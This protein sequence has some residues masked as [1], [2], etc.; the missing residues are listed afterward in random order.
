MDITKPLLVLAVFLAVVKSQQKPQISMYPKF[1]QLYSGDTITLCCECD[2]T[3]TVKWFLNE[4]TTTQTNTTWRIAAVSAKNSSGSYT[5]EINGVKSNIFKIEV[6]DFLPPASLL[7]KS[8]MPVVTTYGS[9]VLEL[10]MEDGLQGWNCS[11]FQKKESNIKIRRKLLNNNHTTVTFHSLRQKEDIA[12][13]WC[14]NENHRS[15][16]ITIRRSDQMTVLETPPRPAVL[17]EKLTLHCVVRMAPII[18]SAIFYKDGKELPNDGREHQWNLKTVTSEEQE[19]IVTAPPPK[20]VLSGDMSCSCSSCPGNTYHWYYRQ[21]NQPWKLKGKGES[22]VW[23]L[24]TG[25]E[26]A[27]TAVWKNGRSA[28]SNTLRHAAYPT[29]LI[30]SGLVIVFGTILVIVAIVLFKRRRT[31]REAIYQDVPL[32]TVKS[33]DGDRDYEQLRKKG[34]SVRDGEYDTLTTPAEDKQKRDGEY[35]ALTKG[36]GNEGVY[37]T[38]GMVGEKVEVGKDQEYQTLVEGTKAGEGGYETLKKSEAIG[39]EDVQQKLG[40][41]GAK[42]EADYED[43][44]KSKDEGAEEVRKEGE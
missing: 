34:G 1:N 13:Y 16:T 43:L 38:V 41:E 40:G 5:C 4:S 31:K 32:M 17:G 3:G 35:Q 39:G 33:K 19:L 15:T 28:L 26:Y 23:D 11:V 10:Q 6:L 18:S 20:A 21:Q 44:T 30:L 25:T 2:N 7:I 12:I 37:H 29:M 22:Y 24:L 14:S 42:A 9:V 27:C 36:E 8:G